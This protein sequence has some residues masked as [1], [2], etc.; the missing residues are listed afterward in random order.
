MGKDN[1][2]GHNA[3]DHGFVS[4][5]PIK[6]TPPTAFNDLIKR[7]LVYTSS[8]NVF[9]NYYDGHYKK[10]NLEQEWMKF[11]TQDELFSFVGDY[12]LSLQVDRDI[13]TPKENLIASAKFSLDKWTRP[14]ESYYNSF[15]EVSSPDSKFRFE[16]NL[17]LA[18]N[19]EEFKALQRL[20]YECYISQALPIFVFGTLRPGQ[21]NFRTAQSGRAIEDIRPAKIFGVA[22]ISSPESGF[23]RSIVKDDNEYSMVGDLIYLKKSLG[24]DET[25]KNMDQLESFRIKHPSN[26]LY[27]RVARNVEILK[28]DGTIQTVKAWVYVSNKVNESDER[29]TIKNGDWFEL[30][31]SGYNPERRAQ[32]MKPESWN[33][34]EKRMTFLERE[35][36]A[37]GEPSSNFK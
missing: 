13:K 36:E 3:S 27:N 30:K 26:S 29:N 4:T 12:M 37:Y 35:I 31:N 17:A 34:E 25:R 5:P 28:D 14:D 10:L 18:K 19:P 11:K 33:A 32:A 23:P 22:M 1:N 9:E 7:E 6:P 21:G 8:E 20:G 2:R 15:E 16:D 24:G